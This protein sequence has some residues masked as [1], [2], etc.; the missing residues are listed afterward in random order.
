MSECKHEF[1]GVKLEVDGEWLGVIKVC[2]NCLL[3]SNEI[4]MDESIDDLRKQLEQANKLAE[5]WKQKYQYA[6]QCDISNVSYSMG[7]ENKIK[8]ELGKANKRIRE[9]ETENTLL[10]KPIS[11]RA[12]DVLKMCDDQFHENADLRAQL[13]KMVDTRELLADANLK[14]QKREAENAVMREALEYIRSVYKKRCELCAKDNDGCPEHPVD[15]YTAFYI[16]KVSK[17]LQSDSGANLLEVARCA[18]D[19]VKCDDFS[20]QAVALNKLRDALRK[21]RG[22]E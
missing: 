7:Q 11:Q 4:N 1:T 13:D 6:R 18:E 17:A 19:I 10:R 12:L 14:L 3:T 9:L 2:K 15:C 5:D 20:T 22:E 8:I 16:E 21:W